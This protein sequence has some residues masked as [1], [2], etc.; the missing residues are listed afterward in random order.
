MIL[1]KRKQMKNITKPALWVLFG[2]VLLTSTVVAGSID[3]G[4]KIYLKEIKH[5][6]ENKSGGEF[7][8]S[9]K[10]KDWEEAFKTGTFKS[11]VK[12]ICPEL[13]DYEEKWT[14]YLFEFCYEYAA[15]TG[16]EPAG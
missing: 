9:L 14:P 10:Q 16:N 15:D 7:A 2:F 5:R 13:E 8:K 1:D 11:K 6:C 4:Q 12:E 3:K